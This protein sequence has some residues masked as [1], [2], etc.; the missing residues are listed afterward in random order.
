MKQTITLTFSESVENHTGMEI[1]GV[2]SDTGISAEKCIQ[3]AK[4]YNG[5]IYDLSSLVPEET[6]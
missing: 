6:K 1:I 2:K 3:L 4:R 5:L